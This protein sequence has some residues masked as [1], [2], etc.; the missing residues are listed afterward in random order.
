ML[1]S[2]VEFYVFR[3]YLGIAPGSP[4][5]DDASRLLDAICARVR[6]IA[7]LDLEGDLGGSYDQV[8]RIRGAEEFILPHAPVRAIASISRVWFDGTQDD[9]YQAGDWRLDDAARGL[10]RL[11]PGAADFSRFHNA[12][13]DRAAV[14]GLHLAP[15]YVRVVWTTTGEIPAEL[16]QAVLEWGRARWDERDANPAL[17]AYTTGTDS[18]T[19]AA[20]LAGRPPREVLAAILGARHARGGAVV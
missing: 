14:R 11:R 4:D 15:D 1:P 18:E 7:R 6:R 8:I 13:A 20:T 5:E 10:V 12:W 9:P 19:Y 16:P 3:D 17:A 2:I